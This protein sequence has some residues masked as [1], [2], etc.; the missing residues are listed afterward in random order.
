MQGLNYVSSFT[1]DNYR[2]HNNYYTVSSSK[3]TNGFKLSVL[4]QAQPG[5]FYQKSKLGRHSKSAGQRSRYDEVVIYLPCPT[6]CIFI[7]LSRA[8]SEGAYL[9]ETSAKVLMEQVTILTI[10]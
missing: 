8:K 3:I 5:M 2:W 1:T 4:L 9:M 7:E 10:I 6:V